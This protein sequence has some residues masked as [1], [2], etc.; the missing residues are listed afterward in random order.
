MMM[1]VMMVIM[2]IGMMMVM[3][4][5]ERQEQRGL[6]ACVYWWIC[7]G[8]TPKLRSLKFLYSVDIRTV[9]S[10]QATFRD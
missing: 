10:Q 2:M 7:V 1:M 6:V 3:L 8:R 4:S 9:P 5:P